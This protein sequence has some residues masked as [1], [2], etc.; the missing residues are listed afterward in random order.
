MEIQRNTGKISNLTVA[1]NGA[2]VFYNASTGTGTAS[3]ILSSVSTKME[4]ASAMTVTVTPISGEGGYVHEN[5]G[6]TI[7]LTAME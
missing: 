7:V 1:G 5:V 2:T 3:F 6:A 4:L